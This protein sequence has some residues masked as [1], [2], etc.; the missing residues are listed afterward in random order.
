MTR[1]PVPAVPAKKS[2]PGAVIRVANP[3]A[4]SMREIEPVFSP[5][6]VRGWLSA[7]GL[8]EFPRPTICIFNGAPLM[9]ADWET[10]RVGP[11]DVC[12]FV[13]VPAGGGGGGGKNPLRTVLSIAIMVAGFYV[14][15]AYGPALAQAAGFTATEAAFGAV[16]YGQLFGGLASGAVTLVGA[17]LTSFLVPPG[18]PAAPSL[19]W[20]GVASPAA[21]PTYSLAGQGN[22]ARLGQP[23]PCQ[24]GRHLVY[25]DLVGDPYQ[26]YAA[27][28]Q[29]L[30]SLFCLGQGEYANEA[31]RIANTPIANFAEVETEIV[32]P[33]GD[34]TLFWPHVYVPPEVAGQ[35]LLAPNEL[36][37]GGDGFIGPF[38]A[39][40]VDTSATHVGF[41]V[42]APRG[43]YYAND[44]GGLD[45]KT[46]QWRVEARAIDDGGAPV[47]LAYLNSA[48]GSVSFSANPAASDT[49]TLNGVAWTFVSG[50]PGA[51]QTQIGANLAATL[52]QLASDLN[53]SAN[54]SIDDATYSATSD[55][56]KI[57]HDT[58]GLAGEAFTLAASA[59]EVSAPHLLG[60]FS[61]AQGAIAFDANPSA[62]ATITLNGV[63]WTFVSGA[64][65]GNQTQIGA[66]LAATLTQLATDLNA[67][68]N[69]SIAEATYSATA[70]A[71][72]I[73]HDT[74]GLA[75]EAF[76]LAASAANPSAANLEGGAFGAIGEESH[77]AATNAAVRLS[78]KYEVSPGRYE[79]RARRLDTKDTSSR[80]GHELAWPQ[81][82]AYLQ[83]PTSFGAVT[84]LAVKMRA[85]NNLSG[86]SA[87]LVNVIQ[88]RKLPVWNTGAQSWSAPQATR[89]PVWAAADAIRAEYG[90]KLPDSRLPLAD[91][92]TLA[93]ALA[94]RGD[95]FDFV[96][97]TGSTIWN[98]L[99][100][101]ARAGRCAPVQTGGRVRL[102][103]DQPQELPAC[104]FSMR[105]I[106]R[107]SFGMKHL[108]PDDNT[109]NAVTVE[110]FSER[111]WKPAEVTRRVRDAAYTAWLAANSLT[112]TESA[113][114]QWA[115]LAT[116]PVRR[117]LVGVTGLD[118]ARRE[119]DFMAAD[120]RYRRVLPK[121]MT[122]MDGM[123][124]TFGD[125]IAVS[126][127][128]PDWGLSG[129]LESWFADNAPGGVPSGSPPW[130]NAIL[131][132]TEPPAFGA[133]THYIALRTPAGAITGPYECVAAPGGTAHQVKIAS[134][135]F[136]PYVG[137]EKERTH[138][139]FGP[140]ADWSRL[141]RV[142]A[143]RPRERGRRVE[144]AVVVEDDR[145]HVN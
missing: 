44:S 4:P 54:A 49:V 53:A 110:Y 10:T 125:L 46:V 101:I 134:L 13:A 20:G 103:R 116:K 56:L 43:L 67:S 96:F 97:D 91:Y 23:I 1:S 25:P 121:F 84:M 72:K 3:F 140:G 107:G 142:V 123:I 112:D 27:N 75:G 139:Q 8:A 69:A 17:A 117:K 21:S 128:L 120:N 71:L 76:T 88:T 118:H 77:T 35:T 98:A 45:S 22:Q 38:T 16:T 55:A 29:F 42:V 5:V 83:G 60:G 79:L 59:A 28:E 36:T 26:E 137:A 51:N 104:M 37:A 74:A 105:N 70:D 24:Y 57:V 48:R 61:K 32:A 52:T 92:A 50:S 64:P 66:N 11:G 106:A 62:G 135:P 82:R 81:A 93:A 63:A 86:R 31:V 2:R 18:K 132:L 133:G 39:N 138:F 95:N 131:T 108:L 41:D 9:R 40:P 12:A 15:A 30:F 124:P 58:A 73:V 34:V 130:V 143:L 109:A 144:I 85:T 113:R 115:A 111:T 94:A 126:H 122:E 68:A 89:S 136:T 90:A 127:D 129:E 145:V 102:F 119:A 6:T 100:D 80:A 19:N 47:E 114:D 99:T 78:H 141:C 33:D 65:S 7:R 87:R 14:G